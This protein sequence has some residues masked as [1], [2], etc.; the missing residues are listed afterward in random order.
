MADIRREDFPLPTLGPALERLRAEVLNGRG[1]VLLRGMPVEDRPIEESA[2][3]LLGRRH[4][5]RQRPLAK[6]Q[7]TFARPRL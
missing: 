4:I 6:R 7:G 2:D 1:F 5:F 3:R